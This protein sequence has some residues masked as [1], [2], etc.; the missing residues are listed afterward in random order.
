MDINEAIEILEGNGFHLYRREFKGGCL[1]GARLVQPA[2]DL[3]VA[4]ATSS[5][6][7]GVEAVFSG[8]G[9]YKVEPDHTVLTNSAN[10]TKRMDT[11]IE[12][13][14]G[15]IGKTGSHNDKSEAE[16]DID[17]ANQINE[18]EKKTGRRFEFVWQGY[19]GFWKGLYRGA[20]LEI[21]DHQRVIEM[22]G[23]EVF[24]DDVDL[25]DYSEINKNAGLPLND[26]LDE[27]DNE[28]G[29]EKVSMEEY[30]EVVA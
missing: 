6:G 4:L 16:L 14:M 11:H 1:Y 5:K 3:Y 22:D 10:L 15:L 23:Y 28:G 18:L 21:N 8:V 30:E 26:V 9:K 27:I 25:E 2:C 20:V 17:A 29:W 19:S 7:E 24:S 13:V 12:C